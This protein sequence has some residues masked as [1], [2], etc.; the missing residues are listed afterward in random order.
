MLAGSSKK[1]L[2]TC[3]EGLESAKGDEKMGPC[4]V[5]LH[6]GHLGEKGRGDEG[7]AGAYPSGGGKRRL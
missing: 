6:K 5:F 4:L 3:L 7:K 1:R 2:K